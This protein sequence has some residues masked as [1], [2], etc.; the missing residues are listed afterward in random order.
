M[1][2]EPKI[3]AVDDDETNLRIL[4]GM[5]IPMGYKVL[6][7]HDGV[8]AISI[9]NSSEI[10]LI[11]LDVMMP[12]MDGFETTKILKTSD[13][14]KFIPIVM[15]TALNEV[16]HRVKALEAGADDFLTKPVEISELRARVK[17]LI[18]VK[19]YN[20]FMVD[21]KNFLEEEVRKKTI[22]LKEAYEKIKESSLESIYL[23]SKVCEY[24]DE[25][26]GAHILRMSHYAA[27]IAQ[28]MGQKPEFVN[29]LLYSTPMHDIGKIG[30]PDRILLKHGKLDAEEFEIMKLHTVF[31]EKIL[32]NSRTELMQIAQKIAISHHE[33]WDGSGYPYRLK[34]EAIPIEG[35]IT[36]IA[37]VFDALTS[38]RPYKEPLA[39]EKS[40][41]IIRESSNSHFSPSVVDAF[42]MA[43]DEILKVKKQ[44]YDNGESILFYLSNDT[45]K[46]I[47]KLSPFRRIT[48]ET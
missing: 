47:I 29:N 2:D 1:K 21:S 12:K 15:V 3:L 24:R 45:S 30:I 26:T 44:Y 8:E 48:R 16:Y 20:D 13:K 25:D 10:D 5:L 19:A 38:K 33:K 42:F 31:G 6:R 4:D 23:L 41:E 7:A 9:A 43:L 28:K 46:G 35:Q 34:G 39:I 11:L 14:T 27:I 18:K 32:Q 22:E 36:A 40:I 37:D 17:S